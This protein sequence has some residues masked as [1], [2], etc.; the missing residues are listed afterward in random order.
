[1]ANI[2]TFIRDPAF[3]RVYSKVGAAYLLQAGR[4]DVQDTAY[5]SSTLHRHISVVTSEQQWHSVTAVIGCS[6]SRCAIQMN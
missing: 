2:G 3:I 4:A 1:M 6:V 5:V